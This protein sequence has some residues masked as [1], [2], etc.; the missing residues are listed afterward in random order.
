MTK[1]VIIGDVGGCIEELADALVAYE[2]DPD[3]VVVQVGDLVD[4]GPDSRGVLELVGTR[5][6]ERPRRWIQLIGNHEWQ[7]RRVGGRCRRPDSR[8]FQHRGFRQPDLAVR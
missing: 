5:L 2:H 4:R 3:V 7:Y 1:I 8:A 6:G